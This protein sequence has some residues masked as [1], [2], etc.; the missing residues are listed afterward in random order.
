[1]TA[2]SR[3]SC[4]KIREARFG[5]LAVPKHY[6][7]NFMSVMINW[8]RVYIYIYIF[9]HIIYHASLPQGT[10]LEFRTIFIYTYS[11]T[12]YH[13]YDIYHIFMYTKKLGSLIDYPFWNPM[14]HEGGIFHPGSPLG[15]VMTVMDLPCSQERVRNEA[16]IKEFQSGKGVVSL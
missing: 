1:M 2:V 16:K 10:E 15:G 12:D 9:R 7:W 11:I 13:P 6:C 4:L 8:D 14:I 3:W 5:V